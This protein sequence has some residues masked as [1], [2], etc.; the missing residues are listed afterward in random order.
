[1]SVML[2]GLARAAGRMLTSQQTAVRTAALTIALAAVGAPLFAATP[3][4][5]RYDDTF[6]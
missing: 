3:L 4:T 6:R 2:D 1:M 5:E